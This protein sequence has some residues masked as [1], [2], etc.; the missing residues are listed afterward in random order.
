MDY[1]IIKMKQGV[2]LDNAHLKLNT[3]KPQAK[4]GIVLLIVM[5]LVGLL[6]DINSL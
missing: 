1:N 2:R 6:Q 3:M 4:L 5:Y